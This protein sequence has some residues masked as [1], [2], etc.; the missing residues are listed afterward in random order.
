MSKQECAR[1][2]K[3][4]VSTRQYVETFSVNLMCSVSTN[5]LTLG[6]LLRMRENQ[7]IFAE[8]HE[9]TLNGCQAAIEGKWDEAAKLFFKGA[10]DPAKKLR[11]V[12]IVHN[13]C[14]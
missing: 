9:D 13:V 1:R 3:V 2:L 5:M 8:R 14:T 6:S 12:D 10:D 7:K 4:G 11:K